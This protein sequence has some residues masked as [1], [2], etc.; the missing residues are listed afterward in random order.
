MKVEVYWNLKR[1]IYSIRHKGR[2]IAYR[3]LVHMRDVTWV[4]QPAGNRKVRRT[5]RKNVHAFARGTWVQ[6]ADQQDFDFDT[7]FKATKRTPITYN[8]YHHTR[9]VYRQTPDQ[10]C[11]FTPYA[12]LG[13]QYHATTNSYSPVCYVHHHKPSID[14]DYQTM[15]SE[16]G[17]AWYRYDRGPT[18]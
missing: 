15:R 3:T 12:T 2:V 9:F 18:I 16:Y 13:S 4:V 7:Q 5:G 6:P 10:V 17:T 14:H 11:D 8:P 1:K